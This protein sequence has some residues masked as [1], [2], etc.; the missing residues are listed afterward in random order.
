MQKNK[1]NRIF[2]KFQKSDPNPKGELYYK[3]T[4]TLLI[5]VVLSAQAT[6]KS[7]NRATK[8]LFKLADNPKKIL[9]LGERKLIRFIKN[10]GLFNSKAHNIIMLCKILL[11][12]YNGRVPSTREELMNLPGVG[13]KTANVVL[14]IAFNKPTIA[15]DTHLFRLSNRIGIA[16]GKTPLE[17]EKN[18]L[19]VLPNWAL[20]DAHHWLILHGRYVCKAKSPLCAHCLIKNECEYEEKFF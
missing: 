14:N 11:E 6:D 17:V 3:N 7:V 4:F 13:R 9:V 15:V 8:K 10:I 1:I 2:K 12:R 20:E 16:A 18:L 19:K 5:A